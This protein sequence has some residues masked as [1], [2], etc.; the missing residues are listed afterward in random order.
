MCTLDVDHCARVERGEEAKHQLGVAVV[1]N[2]VRVVEVLTCSA[3]S[4]LSC[5][6]I[7]SWMESESLLE[8]GPL[9]RR[10]QCR[11]LYKTKRDDGGERLARDVREKCRHAS[12]THAT[13]G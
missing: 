9:W 10:A 13:Q 11:L 2:E 12:G 6:C 7:G 4:V 8:P 1:C 5:I 3:R